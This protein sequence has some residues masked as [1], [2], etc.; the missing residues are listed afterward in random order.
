MVKKPSA[1]HVGEGSCVAEASKPANTQIVVQTN[2]YLLLH[3][4]L[5]WPSG[6]RRSY[7]LQFARLKR[8]SNS[9]LNENPSLQHASFPTVQMLILHIRCV[10]SA[11]SRA[12]SCA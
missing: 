8:S 5:T 11:I 2:G 3:R 9:Q 7:W 6:H 12:S 1:C 4:I 10:A